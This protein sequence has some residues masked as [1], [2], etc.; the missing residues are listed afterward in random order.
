MK[1][2]KEYGIL[3]LI[4][5]LLSLYLVFQKKGKLQYELPKIEPI[6]KSAISQIRIRKK[7]SEI[8]VVKEGDSWLITPQNFPA[9][10]GMIETMLDDLVHLKL[11][12]LASESKSYS[13]YELHDEHRIEVIIFAGETSLRKLSI[14]KP[15]PSHRHTFVRL[16][17]DHR[18][19]HATDNLRNRFDKT[20][21]DL[22]DKVVMKIDEEIAKV[23]L[24]KGKKSMTLVMAT[25]PVSVDVTDEQKGQEIKEPE[26]TWQTT[27]GKP[28]NEQVVNDL[29]NTLR[30]LTCDDFIEGGNKEDYTS[31]I[32]IVSM[33]GAKS[34]TIS[35]FEKKDS[36]YPAISSES[37]YPFQIAE[38]KAKKLM[39]E[40]K[41][42]QELSK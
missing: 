1:L 30:N 15:A 6:E 33:E 28:V 5:A 14:G 11:T 32:Y 38:W 3:I 10:G 37:D 41:D 12:A 23:T 36:Q 17:D 40:F 26:S 21:S 25:F 39:K 35:L 18:V 7:D 8:R 24:T 4:I 20:V 9:D 13:L 31:P 16:G 2:K 27:Q 42:F 34:Y 19:F 29:I 22:R